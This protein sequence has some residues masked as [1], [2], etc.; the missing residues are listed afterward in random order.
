MKTKGFTRNGDAEKKINFETIKRHARSLIDGATVD[1]EVVV[2]PGL[3]R[4]KGHLI[5]NVCMEK[6]FRATFNK[7]LVMG[8]AETEAIGT[9]KPS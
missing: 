1:D 5:E 7:R 9:R 8:K 6:S 2:Y 4:T 3:R